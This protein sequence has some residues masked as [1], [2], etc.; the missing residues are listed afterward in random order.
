[1]KPAPRVYRL[2]VLLCLALFVLACSFPFSLSKALPTSSSPS[3]AG[4][5][6]LPSGGEDPAN[7]SP[8][9]SGR[10]LADPTAGLAGLKSYHVSFRQDV[11]GTLDGQPF[12]R[13]THI[14][15]TLAAGSE[16]FDFTRQ[17]QTSESPAAYLRLA[18]IGNALY[19]W[20]VAD[21]A[22]QGLVGD[23]MPDEVI[24]PARLLLPVIQAVQVAKETVNQVEAVHYHFDQG[25]LPLAEP[26]DAVSGD[27]WIAAQGGYVV[28]YTLN[29]PAPS[30]PTGKGQ[31]T[32]QSWAYELSQVNA[33]ESIPLPE[34]CMPVPVDIPAVADA[35]ELRQSSGW[36]R[37][38]SASSGDQIVDFY[39]QKLPTLGWIATQ[40]RPSGELKLPY[41]MDFEKDGRY[42]TLS[43]DQADPGGLDVSLVIYKPAAQ[44][45]LPDS[46]PEETATPTGPQPTVDPAVSGLPDD[47]P[48]YPG[49]TGLLKMD[50]MVMFDVPDAPDTVA[51]YYRE[52]MLAAHWTLVNEMDQNGQIV[53]TWQKDGRILPV[54]VSTESG[55]TSVMVA[56]PQTQ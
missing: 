47:V 12:E 8:A 42:L 23:Q 25:G 46:P 32:A 27:V 21:D 9:K 36:M 29:A 40:A 15:L 26:K 54:I 41:A 34:S 45:A 48:L 7:P 24:E 31:E 51:K 14:E 10:L 37:Y 44:T 19:R 56:L 53:Q 35:Q 22:C 6:T 50:V 3:P 43:I 39:A 38:T 2:F 20:N 18:G 49:A 11:T 30:K 17:L 16:Q 4:S 5:R 28:K 55:K 33:V 13:H 1:M 52:K